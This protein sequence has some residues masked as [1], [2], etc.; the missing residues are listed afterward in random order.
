M[1]QPG[2]RVKTKERLRSRIREQDSGPACLPPPPTGD[3]DRLRLMK[4]PQPE[5]VKPRGN[6]ETDRLSRGIGLLFEQFW[7]RIRRTADNPPP[8][9]CNCPCQVAGEMVP[10]VSCRPEVSNGIQWG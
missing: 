1:P 4:R 8:K 7:E 9:F 10:C 2:S 3:L 6:T 5:D